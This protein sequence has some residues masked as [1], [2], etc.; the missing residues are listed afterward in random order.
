MNGTSVVQAQLAGVAVTPEADLDFEQAD[1]FP[2]TD[3]GAMV[4]LTGIITVRTIETDGSE[5]E[6]Q[7]TEAN[8]RVLLANV[9]LP[10]PPVLCDKH[11]PEEIVTWR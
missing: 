1:E 11:D 7:M 2:C 5:R 8:A 10:P 3:C 4:D 6:Q 9:G